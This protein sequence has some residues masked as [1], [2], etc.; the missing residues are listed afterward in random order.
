[1]RKK[2]TFIV[3][4][5][6]SVLFGQSKTEI[7]NIYF[8]KAEK[9]MEK[10]DYA[11]AKISFEKGLT[12]LE[13]ITSK[14]VAQQGAFIY[15]E[16]KEYT[17]SQSYASS[18]LKISTIKTSEDYMQMLELYVDME[19]IISKEKEVK[20]KELQVKLEKERELK[21]IDS[22]K[23]V[24]VSK[25]EWFTIGVDSLYSFTSKGV[26]L[27]EKGKYF[28]LINDVG[29][30]VLEA[31]TYKDVRKNEGYFVF[32][33]DVNSP[34]DIYS[35]NYKSGKSIKIIAPSTH[36]EDLKDYGMIMLPRGNG[37]LVM[38]PEGSSKT[39]VY[40][41]EE[42]KFI[43]VGDLKV[44]FKDL[45]KAKK[46]D[47]YDEKE[48]TIK[49]GKIWYL[50][51]GH[52]GSDVYTL[53]S[54]EDV[55]LK[56]YLFIGD[57]EEEVKMFKKKDVGFFG[58]YHNNKFEATKKGNTLWYTND[59]EEG[60]PPIFN[61]KYKGLTEVVKVKGGYQLVKSGITILGSEKL[62]KLP[63]FL[64]KNK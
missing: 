27:Y 40:D 10:I 54:V 42:E 61:D 24:W 29:E 17:K 22:L 51:G 62:E 2:L 45:K 55:E 4:L 44:L 50:F 25:K 1:M 64:Q 33:D 32:L 34:K 39:L 14:D 63:E 41:L 30:V 57:D 16:L 52:I 18:F 6:V 11:S 37:R 31:D 46:I 49:I 3:L 28:G 36:D 35:Y 19:D 15:Y 53:Y 58:A 60:S 20:A 26:A 8:Q 47:K 48:G 7:A 5:T 9:F 38:Y 43:K 59:G 13:G 56:S 23:N 12:Y 21:R